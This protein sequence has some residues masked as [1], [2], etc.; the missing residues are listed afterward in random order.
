[1]PGTDNRIGMPMG[2]SPQQMPASRSAEFS[3]GTSGN[4]T[5][6]HS[7]QQMPSRGY[8]PSSVLSPVEGNPNG[9]SS[10]TY[11]ANKVLHYYQ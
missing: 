6:T 7:V 9:Q 3:S 10:S 1:M 2:V 11:S 5:T 8:V 4:G